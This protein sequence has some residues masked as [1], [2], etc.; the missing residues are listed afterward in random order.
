MSIVCL[1]TDFGAGDHEAGVLKGVIWKIAPQARIIDL[2]HDISPHDVLEGALVLW[3]SAPYFP[4]NTIFVGVVDPG[5]GTARRAIAGQVGAH[6]FV[7]PDNGLFSLAQ[8]RVEAEGGPLSWVQ[9]DKPEYWLPRVTSIFHGRDIFSP[10]AA[11]LAAGRRLADLGTPLDDP[12]RLVVPQPQRSASGWRAPII[13]VDHFGNL[14]T[15]L[16][17]ALLARSG[18]ITIHAAGGLIHGLS[19]SFGERAPGEL[20]AVIDSSGL[21]SIAVVNGSAAARLGLHAGDWIEVE[22]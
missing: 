9:L 5:V 20:A 13:H 1:L 12:V 19:A 21:L 15:S 16:P 14:A 17:E 6:Y 2:T 11:H 8:E 7:G 10:A 4:E 3:R 22:Q 18:P